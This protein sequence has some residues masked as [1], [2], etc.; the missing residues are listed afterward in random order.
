MRDNKTLLKLCLGYAYMLNR[1]DR[2]GLC[3]LI[4]H[5]HYENI[6]NV[7]E[8]RVLTFLFRVNKPISDFSYVSNYWWPVSNVVSRIVFLEELILQ[9]DDC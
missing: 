9:C 8:K 3:A 6:I 5:L 4:Y 1:P 2:R 7:D